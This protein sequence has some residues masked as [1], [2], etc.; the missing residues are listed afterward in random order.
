MSD[1]TEA[2]TEQQPNEADARKGGDSGNYTPPATQADLDK[3][4]AERLA[5]ERA[6]F[7]DYDEL[8]KKAAEY[9]KVVELN[10]TEAEKQAERLAEL[11]AKVAEYE[12]REQIA[13]WKAEVSAE[14]GVPAEV[15]K[16]S[17]KEEIAEHAA[18]LKPLIEQ[19]PTGPQPVPG[20]GNPGA[21]PLNS[22]GIEAALKSALGI[23]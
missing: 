6:K 7:G 10:K 23:A 8:K 11:E 9:D 3:I 1:G 13:A 4:I 21:I 14:T 5:R 17:T 22:D 15:L 2:T 16:G 18:T 20:E 12:T 19:K